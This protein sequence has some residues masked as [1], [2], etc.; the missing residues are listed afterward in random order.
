M[1]SWF[2]YLTL[3]SQNQT[4]HRHCVQRP[5]W[6]NDREATAWG[7]I[8]PEMDTI[9][10]QHWCWTVRAALSLAKMFW[11]P[12]HPVILQPWPSPLRWTQICLLHCFA[13]SLQHFLSEVSLAEVVS[14]WWPSCTSGLLHLL[15]PLVTTEPGVSSTFRSSVCQRQRIFLR[16]RW[17]PHL[18]RSGSQTLMCLRITWRYSLNM[19]LPWQPCPLQLGSLG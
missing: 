7:C 14:F 18:Y 4:I 17:F 3:Y 8:F 12:M 15:H 11:I 13:Q 6:V 1:G 16:G 19:Q 9:E 2:C 10:M 5:P